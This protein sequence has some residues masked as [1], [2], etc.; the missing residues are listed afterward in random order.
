VNS[1]EAAAVHAGARRRRPVV[2]TGLRSATPHDRA[3]RVVV[4][5]RRGARQ[6]AV[7]RPRHAHPSRLAAR[8]LKLLLG[9][10]PR[11]GPGDL[12]HRWLLPLLTS[13]ALTKVLCHF[14]LEQHRAPWR[15]LVVGGRRRRLR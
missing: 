6:D 4:R 10:R 15:V 8:S 13:I 7:K 2:A 3:E 12:L 11:H 1:P 9:R 14:D 5:V